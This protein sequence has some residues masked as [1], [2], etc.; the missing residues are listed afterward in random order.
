LVRFST[1]RAR[2][3]RAITVAIVLALALAGAAPAGSIDPVAVTSV[4]LTAGQTLS[5]SIT[6]T[7]QISGTP[8]HVDFAIDGKVLWTA[9]ATPYTFNGNGSTLDTTALADGSHTFTVTASATPGKGNA[10]SASVSATVSN[11]AVQSAPPTTTSTPATTSTTTNP[12]TS[13]SAPL[14]TTPPSIVGT[15][16]VGKTLTASSGTWTGTTPMSYG[17]QWSNCDSGGKNCNPIANATAASYTVASNLVGKTLR[18]TITAKNS[19]GS[20]SVSSDPTAAV[21]LTASVATFDSETA[22]LD[23]PP[24]SL[25][26]AVI[27]SSPSDF[28]TAIANAQAG[29]VIDVLGN[30]Q[31]PGEFTGFNRVI[32]GGTVDVVFQPGAGFVGSTVTQT[33][34]ARFPAV[35][36]ENSGGWRLWGGTITNHGGGSGIL[37]YQMPGPFTWTGFTVKDTADTCVSLLP[38]AGN[39]SNVTLKGVAGTAAPNLNYDPH[40]EKGTGI[41]AWNLADASGGVLENVTVAADTLNQATGAA[42]ELDMG[43]VGS[44]V[45]IFSRAKHLG[46]A[47]PGT[48]WLGYAQQQTAGNVLQLWGGSIPSGGS[49][50]VAYAEGNDIQGRMLETS[51]ASSG[52]NYSHASIDYGIAT[53]PIME[54]PLVSTPAYMV[55]TTAIKLGIVSPLP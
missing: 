50:D 17:Y 44:N 30:V 43:Q 16:T 32:S 26:N 33:V 7:A 42:V 29:Q 5:G 10:I 18:A 49:L 3:A 28:A 4:G 39:I 9:R 35:W 37:M 8:N 2:A 27:V 31:I 45:K 47:V 40:A 23:T 54:S 36:I 55:G 46:F 20:L 52:A 53:G 1:L 38:V 34:S 51:G 19:V 24:P 13:P 12:T 48:T 22:S 11:G 25:T 21:T 14:P 6:W 41:H 15:A